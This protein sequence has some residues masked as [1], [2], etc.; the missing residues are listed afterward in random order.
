M[1]RTKIALRSI[2]LI[3]AL[4]LMAL[5]VALITKSNLGTS[6]ISSI[7][8]VLSLIFPLTFGEFTTLVN[9]LLVLIQLAI[10][11][12]EFP[13]KQFLQA[14]VGSF[15][16]FFIDFGMF[17]FSSVNPTFYAL[18]IVVLLSGCFILA[19]GIYFEVDANIIV[20]PGEGIVKVISAKS[21]RKFGTIKIAFDCTLVVTAVIISL[22]AFRTVKGIREGTIIS[23]ILVGSMV[24]MVHFICGHLHIEKRLKEV[25]DRKKQPEA[26]HQ[27]NYY[28]VTIS[29]QFGSGGS[30]IGKKLSEQFSV[31]F[32]DRDILKKVAGFLNI[33]ERTLASHEERIDSFWDSFRHL[34][35]FD[36]PM[37]EKG[38]G[39]YLTGK[40]LFELE[41]TFI[42]QIADQ[43]SSVILGRGARY[44]LRN[45][46]RH[47][48]VYVHADLN[49][50]IQ[51]VSEQFQLSKEEAQNLIKKNDAERIAYLK[52]YTQQDCTD[53][54][55]YD[56]CVD[57]SSIGLDN[58]VTIIEDS[59]RYKLK[60]RK[61][62]GGSAA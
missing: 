17:L 51:R 9:A 45:H 33:P 58:S 18:R 21:G 28:V 31:P 48:S 52:S 27:D 62:S 20:N 29:H 47:L 3:L 10:L 2:E 55:I 53:A 34:A 6:P 49:V 1:S 54:R 61:L 7:P 11:K 42:E 4:F 32:V 13:P 35:A 59:L 40:E 16:G 30:Y 14:V 57:T 36:D 12:K 23:A 15:F 37:I 19:L 60:L 25:S 44:I 24:K 46:P 56:I 26:Y 39:Y 43:S 8:Y 50:R 22:I 38:S 5:G 41:S